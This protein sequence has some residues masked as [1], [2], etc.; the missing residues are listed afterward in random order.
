MKT[1]STSA[2]RLV[3]KKERLVSLH[4]SSGGRSD[5]TVSSRLC[6]MFTITYG[7]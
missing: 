3:L 5:L 6:E 1:P 7:R 4:A 2:N